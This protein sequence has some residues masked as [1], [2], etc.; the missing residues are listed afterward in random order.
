MKRWI[1]K[2]ENSM[3]PKLPSMLVHSL[4]CRLQMMTGLLFPLCGAEPNKEVF[5]P[6]FS[7]IPLL[8]YSNK[9]ITG[10][11]LACCPQSVMD[12]SVFSTVFILSFQLFFLFLTPSLLTMTTVLSSH[13]LF[14]HSINIECLLFCQV[15][16]IKQRIKWEVIPAF[17]ELTLQ[18]GK[19][20]KNR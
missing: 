10:L 5:M 19:T 13:N 18:L 16:K 7:S 15:W 17:V 11:S 14:I 12:G 4:G 6:R 3:L 8:C 2:Q 20:A 9:C 1:Q